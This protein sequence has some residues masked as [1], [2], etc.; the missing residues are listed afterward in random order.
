MGASPDWDGLGDRG[1]FVWGFMACEAALP[2]R[3]ETPIGTRLARGA[4]GRGQEEGEEALPPPWPAPTLQ[5]AQP[6][7]GPITHCSLPSLAA[8][9]PGLAPSLGGVCCLSWPCPCVPAIV[10]STFMSHSW[11][12][13]CNISCLGAW[14]WWEHMLPRPAW[15]DLGNPP[16]D[17]RGMQCTFQATGQWQSLCTGQSTPQ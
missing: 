9:S 6:P 8:M 14:P 1:P 13:Q 11:D 4:Q 15:H 17:A 5:A 12:A 7:H 10:P 2:P 16:W 3:Q